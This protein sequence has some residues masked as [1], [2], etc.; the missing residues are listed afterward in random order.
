MKKKSIL[1]AI[2]VGIL[3][4]VLVIRPLT[5]FT[6]FFDEHTAGTSWLDYL[7]NSYLEILTFKDFGNTFFSILGGIMICMLVVMIKARKKS[8][9]DA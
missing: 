7:G 2:I 5:M 6:H 9:N 4:G 1:I 3:L 8:G